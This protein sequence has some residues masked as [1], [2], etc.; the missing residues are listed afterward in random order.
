[1]P[2]PETLEKPRTFPGDPNPPIEVTDFPTGPP[3]GGVNASTQPLLGSDDIEDAAPVIPVT[4]ELAPEP[5]NPKNSYRVLNRR[6]GTREVFLLTDDLKE[7]RLGRVNI[8]DADEVLNAAAQYD[9]DSRTWDVPEAV[10]QS[11][12]K[13]RLGLPEFLIAKA[14]KGEA[15]VLR[16]FLGRKILSGEMTKEEAA[17]RGQ[18]ELLKV[19]LGEEPALAWNGGFGRLVA[20]AVRS[21]GETA[22]LALGV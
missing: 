19:Q 4:P 15:G 16:S 22:R 18:Q 13:G 2:P 3:G 9:P 8:K 17:A 6:D 20:D 7:T 14:K 10:A 1:M 11:L 12:M 5:A 21:P